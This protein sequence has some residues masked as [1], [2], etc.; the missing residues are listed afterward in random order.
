MPPSPSDNLPTVQMQE[1]LHRLASAQTALGR[2]FDT[3]ARRVVEMQSDVSAIAHQLT[4]CTQR[5][6]ALTPPRHPRAQA[7]RSP[8]VWA[9]LAG[10]LLLGGVA[11]YL[12]RGF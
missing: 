4:I 5:V 3:I 8:A 11:G 7:L 1:A 10:A 12:V 2:Y 6:E 9:L